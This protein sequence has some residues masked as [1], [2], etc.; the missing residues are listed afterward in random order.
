[1][2]D[3]D[4]PYNPDGSVKTGADFLRAL[5]KIMGDRLQTGTLDDGMK[6]LDEKD[7]E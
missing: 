6:W 5:K 2:A 1:M 7:A 4:N 3:D